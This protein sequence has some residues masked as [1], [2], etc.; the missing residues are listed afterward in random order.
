MYVPTAFHTLFVD[1]RNLFIPGSR[2]SRDE[3][4]PKLPSY[5]LSYFL[6]EKMSPS[7]RSSSHPVT[8]GGLQESWEET[9]DKGM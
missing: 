7:C 5:L 9:F 4:N 1:K 6:Y 3:L 2:R 8:E